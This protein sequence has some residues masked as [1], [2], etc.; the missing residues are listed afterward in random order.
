MRK[1]ELK[2]PRFL[3]FSCFWFFFFFFFPPFLLYTLLA[4]TQ[5]KK[6]SETKVTMTEKI[7]F[8]RFLSFRFW[9]VPEIENLQISESFRLLQ[10]LII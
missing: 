10:V 3:C 2:F 9:P 4:Q 7:K 8:P 6:L 1:Q 5:N